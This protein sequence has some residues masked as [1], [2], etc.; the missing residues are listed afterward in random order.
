M[1]MTEQASALDQLRSR[2]AQIIDLDHAAAV[3]GWDQQTY[4][5]SGGAPARAEQLATLAKL[6][7]ELFTAAE[8][9][10]LPH[11]AGPDCEGRGGERDEAAPGRGTRG[12]HGRAGELPG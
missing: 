6:S 4:M 1:S 12:E 10:A 9:G 5:P 2:L 8:T 3:L 11:Q 7:H